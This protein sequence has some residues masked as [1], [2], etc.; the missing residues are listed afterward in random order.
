MKSFSME[1]R[2]WLEGFR[3]DELVGPPLY[4]MKRYTYM[5]P[6]Q[7]C[8]HFKWVKGSICIT[9]SFILFLLSFT[10]VWAHPH[11]EVPPKEV[12][13][14]KDELMKEDPVPK[15]QEEFTPF[16]NQNIAPTNPTKETQ[17]SVESPNIKNNPKPSESV[18][19]KKQ[20]HSPSLGDQEKKNTMVSP[21]QEKK[22][23]QPSESHQVPSSSSHEKIKKKTYTDS[24][25]SSDS[26]K[27]ENGGKLPNT[28]TPLGSLFLRGWALL[29]LGLGLRSL[30]R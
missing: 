13:I 5:E 14:P 16:G 19:E 21:S 3:T 7:E 11:Q 23:N 4:D 1:E 15:S 17:E 10:P 27:T 18:E 24:L 22:S 2:E 28:A 25:E 20:S 9:S 29:F 30:K 6:S 8:D 12:L 26:I